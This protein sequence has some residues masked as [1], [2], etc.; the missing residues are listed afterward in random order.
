MP[1][2]RAA[3]D[4]KATQ[5]LHRSLYSSAS[6]SARKNQRTKSRCCSLSSANPSASSRA[7]A[8]FSADVPAFLAP[9]RTPRIA[10]VTSKGQITALS[11]QEDRNIAKV[12]P[13]TDDVYLA[14]FCNFGTSSA[15]ITTSESSVAAEPCAT[16]EAFLSASSVSA[17]SWSSSALVLA[18]SVC[19]RAANTSAAKEA[20]RR[21]VVLS[22]MIVRRQLATAPVAKSNKLREACC[23]PAPLP[24][25]SMAAFN[26]GPV[27]KLTKE[28][29]TKAPAPMAKR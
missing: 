28:A 26:S 9:A 19:K 12:P 18:G 4:A 17:L 6:G 16:L 27:R 2:P 21:S 8:N 20:R 29:N 22:K 13:T 5:A 23:R 14:T 25:T 24:A 3:L 15:H 1:R 11:F 10:P 7:S